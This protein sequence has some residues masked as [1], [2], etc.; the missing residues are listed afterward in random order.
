MSEPEPESD[1]WQGQSQRKGHAGATPTT[2]CIGACRGAGRAGHNPRD[3]AQNRR[4]GRRS[5]ARRGPRRVAERGRGE[6]ARGE[7]KG[8]GD[9]F[10]TAHSL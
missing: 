4:V 3:A 1:A 8:A 5:P 9:V 2:T 7:C 10:S 6:R